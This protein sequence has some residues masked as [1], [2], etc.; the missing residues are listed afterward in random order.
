MFAGLKNHILVSPS[1][2]LAGHLKNSFLSEYETR[3]IN[4]G[5]DVDKFK[6]VDSS[7]I[8]AQY[9][10]EKKYVLG[11]ASKWTKSKGLDDF[12]KL[13]EILDDYFDIVLIGL[14]RSQIGKLPAG[15]KGVERSENIDKLAAL[16]SGAEVFVNPTYVDNFPSVNLE[17]LACGTPVITYNT[18]GSPETIDNHTGTVV[19]KG[20]VSALNEAIFTMINSIDEF[21]SQLC[22]ERAVS[23]YSDDHK[24]KEYLSLYDEIIS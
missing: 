15:I 2:W 23:K 17:A 13:R 11:V 8:L 3:I 18:G 5:I 14:S 1:E 4:N 10:L 9:D 16:Y 12:I 20:S 6:P 22:R 7:K 24:Y 21:T 19:E